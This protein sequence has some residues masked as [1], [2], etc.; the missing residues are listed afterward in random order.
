MLTIGSFAFTAPWLLLGLAALPVLWMLLRLM[1]PAPRRVKFPA[2]R[3]L[4][5]LTG[6]ETTP[7]AVPW[8]ILLLRLLLAALIVLVA[9]R[10]V[11]N[12][13]APLQGTGPLVIAIDDG[14]AAA[15][16]WQDRMD[17][18]RGLVD[19]ADREG[20][21]IHLVLGA[22]PPSGELLEPRRLL[23][24]Q[25]AREAIG[26]LEPKPWPVNRTA[27]TRSVKAL[28]AEGGLSGA[29]VFWLT[30]GLDG[31]TV[32]EFSEALG[33][34]GA[35]NVIVPDRDQG[36]FLLTPPEPGEP[37]L[38]VTVRRATAAT[39][40]DVA[41]IA[42]SDDGRPLARRDAKLAAGET[43]TALTFDMPMELRNAT[44]RLGI[45]NQV[46]AG[47]S[48]LLDERWRR[49]PVG[50][51]ADIGNR[52]ALPLLSEIYFL[53][54]ALAPLGEVDRGPA[55]ILLKVPQSILLLPD[56][57][58]LESEDSARLTDWVEGGGM[59]IRFAGPR[60]AA[61]VDDPLIPVALRSGGRQLSG[62]MLWSEPARIGAV[63]DD[64]PFAG[65]VPPGDVTVTRQVL[66][67][68]SLDLDRKTWMRLA[69]DTPLVT[70][71]RRGDGWLVL[72]HTT[73]NTE[74][75]SLALSGLFV[76]MLERLTAMGRSVGESADMLTAP[77]PPYRLLDGFG[78]LGDPQ[79]SARAI[80]ADSLAETDITA[81]SPP[82]FYGDR[83]RRVSLNLG[84]RLPDFAARYDYPGAR[85]ESGYDLREETPLA[86]YLLIAALVLLA[87][88]TLITASIRGFG[89]LR[90]GLPVLAV[91][92]V[93]SSAP[94]PALAQ[95][96]EIP[97]GARFTVLAYIL[98]GDRDVDATSAAGLRGLSEILRQRT[99]VEA[100]DPVGV[101][102]RRDELAFYPLL[103]WPVLDGSAPI[104][105]ATADRLNRYMASG[106]MILFDTR[107]GHL[108]GSRIGT[109]SDVLRRLAR[110]LDIPRIGAV[111]ADHVLTR[112]FY[113]MQDFPG[114]WSGGTL[115][116]EIG[117]TSNNDGVSPIVV[118]DADWAAAW[119]V[120]D[121]GR[122]L[123]P[124]GGDDE[125]Q[126]EMAYRFGVNLVMYTLTG[127]YKSDQVHI[128]SIL[129][130]LGQ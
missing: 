38:T 36:P 79:N 80:Q 14:W 11:L 17:R 103:Y 56:E 7:Q 110:S 34:L 98:T 88:D 121:Y 66:A 83:A 86:P 51:I 99:A 125:R 22:A 76:D 107:D 128:P 69:D 30:D 115:W 15:P 59:L 113:L 127:N 102:P 109:T 41:V 106:G 12:P 112:S 43:E 45:E 29:D 49:R 73:A 25:A 39:P 108:A 57:T 114:R 104:D 67:E 46:G 93:L 37:V 24:P 87:L 20:R 26:A 1:P 53:D 123:Y 116:V 8:W 31:D 13:E 44:A 5:G 91:V 60:L 28:T 122:P 75:S 95:Q 18:A 94:P 64:G 35:L 90:V 65:L 68:P 85:T 89:V 124:V 63:S 71:D 9:A 111:P 117:G 62:A 105:A 78:R 82:G 81:A 6:E 48:V 47:A 126:R 4:F 3:L 84:D 2:I 55:G 120:D 58:V 32:T 19:L 97:E 92:M 54:R 119:A 23:S 129:E 70:A 16:R 100:G 42:Y 77:M 118:G 130:R 50:I 61:A 52:E 72:V 101:D 27:M 40:A 96:A 33:D 21:E 10:P 74:W